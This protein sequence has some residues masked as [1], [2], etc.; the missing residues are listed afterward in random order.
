MTERLTIPYS[1][2][3]LV[4]HLTAYGLAFVLDDV[5]IDAFVGHDTDSQSFEP[6]VLFEA[7]RSAARDAIRVSAAAAEEIV[8]HDIEPNKTGND[9]RATIW[10]RGSMDRGSDRLAQVIKLR[11][12]LVEEA[13][14]APS[15]VPA[16]LLAGLGAPLSWGSES[17][18]TSSGATAFDGVLGNNTSDFVRGVLRRTREAAAA[19]D[20]DPFAPADQ[21]SP[22]ADK[23]GWAPPGAKITLVHQWL[24]ALGLALL[25]VAHRP[26]ERSATPAFWRRQD[27]RGVTL[28]L[29]DDAVSI[30][31][32]RALLALDALTRIHSG[33]AEDEPA[34]NGTEPRAGGTPL[35]IEATVL[36]SLGVHEVVIFERRDRAGGKSSVAFDFARGRRVAL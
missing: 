8:E 11:R 3:L 21:A 24:A 10:A 2:T 23:T 35:P 5:G 12:E 13:N 34:A 1:G 17:T 9:R 19:L 20:T 6:T 14:N 25:P 30:P 29:F 28:P 31:R 33:H 7:D 26:L 18:R 36:R 15:A 27:E 22:P 32:L 4:S 16:A